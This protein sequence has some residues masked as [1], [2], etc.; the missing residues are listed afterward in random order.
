M[1]EEIQKIHFI[2]IG[3]I[4]MS[5][6]ALMMMKLGKSVSGS[7]EKPSPQLNKLKSLGADIYIGHAAENIGET[8]LVVYS[9]AIRTDNP[10][11]QAALSQTIPTL[12]RAKLLGLLTREHETVAV[13]GAHGK[14]TTSAM[15]VSI[16]ERA[17][18]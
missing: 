10:E 16:L 14:T 5:G 18:M 4:G 13:T 9:T 2:G 3:G 11:M 1:L 8:D 6:L 17:G 12:R 7:D 15:L